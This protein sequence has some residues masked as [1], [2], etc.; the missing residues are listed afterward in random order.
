MFFFMAC[1]NSSSL[2][3]RAPDRTRP[4][5]TRTNRFGGM[6]SF[7]SSRKG[8][9]EMESRGETSGRADVPRWRQRLPNRRPLGIAKPFPAEVMDPGA[10]PVQ[11]KG[12]NDGISFLPTM[13]RIDFSVIPIILDHATSRSTHLCPRCR[14]PS[15]GVRQHGSVTESPSGSA[16][17]N[18]R[19]I[20]SP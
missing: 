15:P 19:E 20:S 8:E 13:G 6:L 16:M 3:V 10:S 18:G 4:T 12:L 7:R 9:T 1:R 2:I 5:L 17:A 14:L 11:T